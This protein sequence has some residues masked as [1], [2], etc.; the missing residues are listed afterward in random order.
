MRKTLLLLMVI[1]SI[2]TS[3]FAEYKLDTNRWE[4]YNVFNDEFFEFFDTQSI[5][6]KSPSEFSAWTCKQFF[7]NGIECGFT[8]CKRK[9]ID[10]KRHFHFEYSDYNFDTYTSTTRSLVIR[11]SEGKTID[12]TVFPNPT[13]S[14]VM[15][16]SVGETTMLQIKKY[17]DEHSNN[18]K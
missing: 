10:K 5:R 14:P 12:S 3:V 18:Q 6:I 16:E 13:P 2:C 11:N 15:P 8:V 1:M 17:I 9:G 4:L 7:D